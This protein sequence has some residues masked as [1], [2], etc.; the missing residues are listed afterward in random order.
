MLALFISATVVAV[1]RF[2]N[3][4][5][6]K[7]YEILRDVGWLTLLFALIEFAYLLIVETGTLAYGSAMRPLWY[8]VWPVF[9]S[10]LFEVAVAVFL[11][12]SSVWLEQAGVA[13]L[14]ISLRRRG[15]G[16]RPAPPVSKPEVSTSARC[17]VE[18]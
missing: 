17:D 13:E 9:K 3:R 4:R 15:G 11:I 5:R 12:L 18:W 2:V 7:I 10:L 6:L 16:L 8:T 1:E 14:R